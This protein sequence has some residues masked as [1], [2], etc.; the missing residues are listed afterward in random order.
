MIRIA[1]LFNIKLYKILI[2]FIGVIEILPLCSKC[3]N[4]ISDINT[5]Y[6]TSE[7]NIYMQFDNSM[8]STGDTVH[9][10]GFTLTNGL[11]TISTKNFYVDWFDE[12]DK[13][14]AHQIYP[15]VN[16]VVAGQWV[17]PNYYEGHGFH[18]VAYTNE[19]LQNDSSHSFRE[20]IPILGYQIVPQFKFDL[21]PEGGN[22]IAG[23]ENRVGYYI[24]GVH[25][26]EIYLIEGSN[27]TLKK[28]STKTDNYGSFVF[29]P[30]KNKSYHLS[31][32]MD[33]SINVELNP[34][35]ESGIAMKTDVYVDSI[36]IMLHKT[37]D[38]LIKHLFLK[39]IM[40][41]DTAFQ[42]SFNMEKKD[43]LRIK[44]NLSDLP[45]GEMKLCLTDES[46]EI[47]AFRSVYITGNTNITN[48]APIDI[49]N[50]SIPNAQAKNLQIIYR[51]SMPAIISISIRDMAFVTKN[52]NFMGWLLLGRNIEDSLL[53]TNKP[54][55][56]NAIDNIMLCTPLSF[57]RKVNT[58]DSS[59]FHLSG[60]VFSKRKLPNEVRLII[61]NEGEYNSLKLSLDDLGHF[62]DSGFI[63]FDSCYIGLAGGQD[64][65]T[66]NIDTLLITHGFERSPYIENKIEIFGKNNNIPNKYQRSLNTIKLRA[67]LNLYKE[68]KDSLNIRHQMLPNVS[69]STRQW[70]SR[71][72]SVKD[73]YMTESMKR[74]FDNVGLRVKDIDVD[75]DPMRYMYNN[76]VD[77]LKGKMIDVDIHAHIFYDEM[78]ISYETARMM[79]SLPTI[80]FIRIIG[81]K[82]QTILI[83]TAK[84]T[85]S[86][87]K[88]RFKHKWGQLI[89]GYNSYIPFG[90]S[91]VAKEKSVSDRR[92]TLFWQ[93]GITLSKDNNIMDIHFD[94]NALAKKLLVVIE[95][96]K[97]DGTPI[98]YEKI[99]ETK[100]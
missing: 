69:V 48:P 55:T 23:V 9:F 6:N 71:A 32:P 34:V 80:G 92:K 91:S 19:I 79:T 49:V 2:I 98:H 94:N 26:T 89:L 85:D 73:I 10:Q 35:K 56:L 59:Y 5:T 99:I 3:Q 67:Q 83:Y 95:G 1:I 28:I 33:S 22:L 44:I 87:L 78:E 88:E 41:K 75:K 30:Q 96:I 57:R 50:N 93:P 24:E 90:Q 53:Q 63:I 84:Y 62:K 65:L 7:D 74:R 11:P 66:F 39:G 18:I 100:L 46:G 76:I 52:R 4:V 45:S 86:N 17:V 64:D 25:P 15:I 51:D 14:L 77:F 60:Q 31:L 38:L 20:D 72:D 40:R 13:L 97:A 47:L 81:I 61:R 21:F 8:Y 27:D 36:T 42:S 70:R 43:S 58:F 29:L 16:S 68:E 82:P 12:K 37:K 54:S